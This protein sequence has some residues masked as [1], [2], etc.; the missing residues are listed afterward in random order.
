M[1][2]R[3]KFVSLIF[4]GTALVFASAAARRDPKSVAAESSP[5]LD[6]ITPAR[7]VS[8]LSGDVDMVPP[9]RGLIL[10]HHLLAAEFI[11]VGARALQHNQPRTI[12]ILGPDHENRGGSLVTTTTHSWAWNG[13]RLPIAV[14]ETNA[15][16][17]RGIATPNDDIIRQEHSVLTPLPFLATA[18]PESRFILLAV[19]GGFYADIVENIAQALTDIPNIDLVVASVDFSH[20][21]DTTTIAA[22]QNANTAILSGLQIESY[23]HLASDSPMSAAIAMR[24]A[25]LHGATHT[26]L[27]GQGDATQFLADPGGQDATS[28]L[29]W[30]YHQ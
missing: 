4:M 20:N 6:A 13:K 28:Y 21:A 23:K 11:G 19:R 7:V 1:L 3:W 5:F 22:E 2:R 15:L 25:A 8:A 16:V 9:P 18:L 30:A 26:T 29:V 24:F 14:E 27:L 12:V 17:A 10:P